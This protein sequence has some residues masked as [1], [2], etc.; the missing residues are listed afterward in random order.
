M[1]NKI[2]D[3]NYW[4]LLILLANLIDLQVPKFIIGLIKVKSVMV[5]FIGYYMEC[6]VDIIT[7]NI[8]FVKL[9]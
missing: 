2:S 4:F 3:I 8:D 6:F 5:D 1:F 9:E 7:N